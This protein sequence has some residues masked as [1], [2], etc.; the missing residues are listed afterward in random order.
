MGQHGGAMASS[1]SQPARQQQG[2]NGFVAGDR[3]MATAPL[4]AVVAD[5][6]RRWY[7]DAQKEALRGDVVGAREISFRRLDFMSNSK[8]LDSKG[9]G[10]MDAQYGLVSVPEDLY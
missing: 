4:K 8:C 10:M 1:S 5:A 3:P 6:V 9:Q 2:S 7:L